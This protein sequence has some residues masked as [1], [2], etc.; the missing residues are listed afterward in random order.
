MDF[1][2]TKF[3]KAIDIQ[4]YILIN[5]IFLWKSEYGKS[6]FFKLLQI[7]VILLS[8]WNSNIVELSSV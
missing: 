4:W 6:K 2:E 8:K 5:L 1:I 3:Y 7:V